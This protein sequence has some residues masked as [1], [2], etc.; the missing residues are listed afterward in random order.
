MQPNVPTQQQTSVS[1]TQQQQVVNTPKAVDWVVERP[2][3]TPGVIS[4]HDAAEGRGP[5]K[6]GF[7]TRGG[8]GHTFTRAP[9]KV[10]GGKEGLEAAVQRAVAYAPMVSQGRFAIAEEASTLCDRLSAHLVQL[11]GKYNPT[12]IEEAGITP[13]GDGS[14][15]GN[16]PWWSVQWGAGH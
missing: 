7:Q 6:P 9:L 13:G 15:T 14:K 2:G 8:P 5:T 16:Q 12:L 4:R 10:A 1:V 11:E 3:G